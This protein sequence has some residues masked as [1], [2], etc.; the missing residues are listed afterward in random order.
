[1]R[2]DWTPD[3]LF[4]NG[5]TGMWQD[6]DSVTVYL[7]DRLRM[8]VEGSPRR[9]VFIGSRRATEDELEMARKWAM[10][11]SIPTFS[12]S[13]LFIGSRIALTPFCPDST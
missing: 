3:E 12:V 8:K 5:E 10:R 4:R 11:P 13:E 7:P 2:S 6:G 9:A 1:M